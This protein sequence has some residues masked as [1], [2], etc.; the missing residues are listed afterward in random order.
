MTPTEARAGDERFPRNV[1]V[2]RGP[3]ILRLLRQG[4]RRR[5]GPLDVFW[6]KNEGTGPRVGVVVPKHRRTIVERNRLR[7]RIREISRR[8]MLPGLKGCVCSLDVL[9]RARPEAYDVGFQALHEALDRF[10]EVLCSEV[11]SSR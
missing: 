9:I 2:H 8:R 7:R 10:T 1:R 3:E 4:E 5:A 11:P 6:K